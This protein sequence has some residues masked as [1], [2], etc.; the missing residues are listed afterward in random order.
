MKKIIN[1]VFFLL[2]SL[3]ICSAN[4]IILKGVVRVR[5]VDSIRI[6]THYSHLPIRSASSAVW[7]KLQN[8][9]FEYR[10][11]TDYAL[12]FIS[13]DDNHLNR[14]VKHMPTESTDSIHMIIDPLGLYSSG[15]GAEKWRFMNDVHRTLLN[16]LP[17]AEGLPY[18]LQ[19][20]QVNWKGMNQFLDSCAIKQKGI[21]S[22]ELLQL[23]KA[24]IFAF[25]A[26]QRVIFL[27]LSL[28]EMKYQIPTWLQKELDQMDAI[29][30]L[31]LLPERNKASAMGYMFAYYTYVRTVLA[32]DI[33]TNMNYTAKELFNQIPKYSSGEVEQY[34]KAIL[35]SAKRKE[36]GM[37]A[38]LPNLIA[39]AEIALVKKEMQQLY[40]SSQTGIPIQ[41]AAFYDTLER[42]ISLDQFKD[43]VLLIDLW[44][45][46][47]VP[48]RK[49]APHIKQIAEQ[50]S[51]RA[52]KVISISIDSDKDKWLNSLQEG[53]YS[54][55]HHVNLF[56]GGQGNAHAFI[57]HYMIISYPTLLLVDKKGLLVNNTI[58]NPNAGELA[59][60]KLIAQIEELLE[61]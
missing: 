13:I 53:L 9:Q 40:A 38:L 46:G 60:M 19:K 48:C 52:F 50:L 61:K 35:V 17:F 39:N 7:I 2:T 43:T 29:S 25:Y 16:R 37:Y 26:E 27:K 56:T 33:K 4:E 58:T 34:A 36:G 18:R 15:K 55:P 22:I 41:F 21:L 57:K 49:T 44:F 47:C 1:I 11:H 8:Q 28:K 51:D 45:T 24:D 12:A 42:K 23:M 20:G 3:Q 5:G 31:H 14:W 30:R 10:L 6:V 59:R 32:M 54:S